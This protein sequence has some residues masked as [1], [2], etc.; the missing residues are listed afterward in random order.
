[1]IAHEFKKPINS[2]HDSHINSVYLIDK[3]VTNILESHVRHLDIYSMSNILNQNESL[4][5]LKIKMTE[6]KS[7]S[8]CGFYQKGYFY[9]Y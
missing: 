6:R 4:P 5:F 7:I 3:L 1:M 2:N 8:S 9:E